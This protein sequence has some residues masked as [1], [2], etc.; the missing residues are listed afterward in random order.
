MSSRHN[1][2]YIW[3]HRGLHSFNPE[4]VPVPNK[5]QFT[6]TSKEKLIFSNQVPP[7]IQATLKCPGSQWT[8]NTRKFSVCEGVSY[9][10][11]CCCFCLF[12]KYHWCFACILWFLTCVFI[13]FISA[14]LPVCCYAFPLLLLFLKIFW[15]VDLF[16]K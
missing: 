4:E 11:F 10:V 7:G 12:F 9:T 2:T 6:T 16:A 1:T 5:N 15:F 14:W 13:G 8:A 3:T